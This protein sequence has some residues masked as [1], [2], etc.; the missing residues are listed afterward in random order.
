MI[1]S[2]DH[3]SIKISANVI[4]YIRVSKTYHYNTPKHQTK[5]ILNHFSFVKRCYIALSFCVP[6]SKKAGNYKSMPFFFGS[7][8]RMHKWARD[9]TGTTIVK[10]LNP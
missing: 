2:L 8:R 6:P 1:L 10:M 5:I 7:T 3:M 9:Q 4:A